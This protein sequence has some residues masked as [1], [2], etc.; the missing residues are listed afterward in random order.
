MKKKKRY[1]VLDARTGK[2]Y[3]C[4]GMS[5]KEV[6]DKLGAKSSQLRIERFKYLD[7]TGRTIYDTPYEGY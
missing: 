6:A 5:I 2:D 4:D 1:W 3:I 7:T